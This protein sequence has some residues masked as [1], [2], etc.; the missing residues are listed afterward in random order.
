MNLKLLLSTMACCL[1]ALQEKIISLF[2]HPIERRPVAFCP[3][4]F[5]GQL[6]LARLNGNET[7]T[8]GDGCSPK[9]ALP[10]VQ[11]KRLKEGPR[12]EAGIFN[13]QMWTSGEE[14]VF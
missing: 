6:H 5:S 10:I 1:P 4:L 9:M 7:R 3:P 8:A 2:C 12:L 11:G 13:F 14:T